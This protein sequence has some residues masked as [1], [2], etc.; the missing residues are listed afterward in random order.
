MIPLR[1]PGHDRGRRLLRTLAIAAL[2]LAVSPT[3]A[4]QSQNQPEIQAHET[5]PQFRIRAERNLVL[6][7][8]VVRDP[9]GRTVGNLHKED[10]RLLDDGKPQ[11][12]TGFSVEV[13]NPKVAAQPRVVSPA[14]AGATT[15]APPAAAVP[16]RFVA[17]FFDDYHTETEGIMRTR[18]AA[19]H[20]VQTTVQPQDRVAIFTATGKDQL[21][22]TSDQTKLHDALFRTLARPQSHMGCPPIDDYEAYLAHKLSDREALGLLHSDAIRCICGVTG[23]GSDLPASMDPSLVSPKQRTSNPCIGGAEWQSEMEAAAVWTRAE[24]ESQYALQAIEQS[25]RRL[26]AMPGQRSLVLVSPGFLT[27]TQQDKV[28]AITDRALQQQVVIS[29]IDAAGLDARMPSEMT[30]VALQGNEAVRIR[31]K[32]VGTFASTGV[33]AYLSADTGGVFFHNSNDFGEGFRQAAAV[34]E[35]YYVLTFSPESVNLN[36]KFHSLKVTLNTHQPF[37]VQARRGYFASE[38]TLAEKAPGGSEL[39]RT[40]FS[41]DERHD[42]PAEVSTK[43][44]RLNEQKSTLI[45]SIHVNIDSLRYRKEADRSVDT[46]IF[47]TALFDH[48]G[49]YVASKEASLELHLKEATL[50]KFSKSGIIARTNFEVSPGT[51][52]VREVVRD[53]ESTDM[54]AL[55]CAV[56]VPGAAP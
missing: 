14:P 30:N 15:A 38:A 24:T 39:E 6:V 44:E 26:A 50:E 16:Q 37:T 54:A 46:L 27:E 7:R 3:S 40:I 49:K 17:L 25:V 36:G 55:N 11:E 41:L 48:D 22:F 13:S 5:T 20:F 35:V 4:Q 21:D 43:A 52:R 23:G 2:S 1:I 47:D 31:L 10:F 56:Q 33:L 45:V 19:W 9:N 12:I 29:A 28:D 8:V 42:L 18:Q 32:N 51:Y 34:P 53:S